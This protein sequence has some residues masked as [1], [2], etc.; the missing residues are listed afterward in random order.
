MTEQYRLGIDTGGTYTDAVIVDGVG[1]VLSANKQ[2]TTHG[3]LAKGIADAVNSMPKQLLADIQ[4]VALSTTLSTNSVV[5]GKGG[6]V[7]V[8]LPGYD[9][10]Q[11]QK[12]GLFDIL[13]S[14][15]IHIIEGGHSATGEQT[16]ELDIAEATR[17][18]EKHA[19]SVS[20]F[21]V[22]SVFATRNTAHEFQ[23]RQLIH[24]LTNK[25]VACG[26]QLAHALGAP[27]RALTTALNARMIQPIQ[28]LIAFQI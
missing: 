16:A 20:A 19:D 13:D 1:N 3:D 23:L 10:A 21:A 18:I 28:E 24:K 6:S 26:H 5:E 25:P 27:R 15:C 8:L 22:S 11:V 7:C 4:M 9:K 2:L 12:S 14:G 17:I